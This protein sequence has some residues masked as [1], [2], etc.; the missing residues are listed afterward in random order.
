MK[1]YNSVVAFMTFTVGIL[2]GSFLQDYWQRP[3][4]QEQAATIVAQDSIIDDKHAA[5]IWYDKQLIVFQDKV[6][7]LREAQEASNI[8]IMKV[9]DFYKIDLEESREEGTQ[10]LNQLVAERL[11]EYKG[12]GGN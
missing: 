4:I 2:V 3:V 5:L 6:S 1:E 10:K 8:L 9:E 7:E 11:K 12:V